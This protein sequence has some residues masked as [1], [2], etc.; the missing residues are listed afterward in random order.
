MAVVLWQILH[1][2]AEGAEDDMLVRD[3]RSILSLQTDKAGTMHGC[4]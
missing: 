1:A 3:K 2:R 4:S